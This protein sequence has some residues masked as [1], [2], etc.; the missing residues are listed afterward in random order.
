MIGWEKNLVKNAGTLG[1]VGWL[2]L[3]HCLGEWQ[4]DVHLQQL[5]PLDPPL[6][7]AAVPVAVRCVLL[8]EP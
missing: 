3:A 7:S 2:L 1:S 6:G 8:C 5:Q 4:P